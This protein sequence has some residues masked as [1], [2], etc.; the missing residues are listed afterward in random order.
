[1]VS[2]RGSVAHTLIERYIF[3]QIYLSFRAELVMID[4]NSVVRSARV[5][6]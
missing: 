4:L 5:M 6:C 2:F 3:H 1:M